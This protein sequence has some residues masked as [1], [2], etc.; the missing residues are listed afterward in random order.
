[1]KTVLILFPIALLISSYYKKKA[2]PD[3]INP[4]GSY[5]LVSKTKVRNGE[6]YG[7]FGNIDV[8]LIG[9]SRIAMSFYVCKGAPSYNSGSFLD[10]LDYINNTT[11][12]KTDFDA[13]CSITFKFSEK[14]IIVDEKASNDNWGCGFG[15]AVVAY[16]FF[17]KTSSKK[18]VIKYP[19][20]ED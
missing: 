10:T 15:H 7:Y 14:G 11:V 13:S 9:S 18:P 1:M 8:E 19:L 17:K 5:K 12:Y 16:G 6:T 20:I 4:T 3:F 2:I